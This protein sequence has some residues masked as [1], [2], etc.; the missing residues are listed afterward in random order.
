MRFT[1]QVTTTACV[2][3][4]AC[5]GAPTGGGG[6]PNVDEAGFMLSVQDYRTS[7]AF[8]EVTTDAYAS[9]VADADIR[10]WISEFAAASY[11]KVD[12]DASGSKV[13]L[14]E[15]TLIIREVYDK[16]GTLKKLT[17]MGKGARGYNPVV[18]D[19]WY[20]VTDPDGTP[21]V[22][23]GQVLTGK[24]EQCFSCHQA[25]GEVDD[26]L[27]GVPAAVRVGGEPLPPVVP[28]PPPPV[29]P[30]PICGDFA[31]E[32]PE[33]CSLC[34]SD[35]CYVD[36]DDEDDDVDEDIDENIEES[37]DD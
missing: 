33:S 34:P 8:T 22:D 5:I 25:R 10:V 24:L 4:S 32:L 16:A 21:Q 31:C 11:V 28:P 35:C 17:L 30:G 26:F 1:T 36:D 3:A 37:V 23:S 27:F 15:G 9:T 12:P 14:P 29:D 13:R 6:A 18:G 2:L 20:A 19:Y 7:G